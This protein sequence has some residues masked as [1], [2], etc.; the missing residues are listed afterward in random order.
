[1]LKPNIYFYGSSYETTDVIRLDFLGKHP[2]TICIST[3][4][5]I[6]DS[7]YEMVLKTKK[8]LEDM[9]I[10]DLSFDGFDAETIILQG[11]G[12]QVSFTMSGGRMNTARRGIADLLLTGYPEIVEK[13][14]YVLDNE[15]KLH[16]QGQLE[17]W[18]TGKNGPTYM[19]VLLSPYG[20]YY[21][22]FYPWLPENFM[23]EYMASTASILFLTGEPG[24]GKTSILR[25]LICSRGLNAAA[26][27][28]ENILSHDEMFLNF[29]TSE[30]MNLIIIEDADNILTPR[31]SNK[32]NLIS[33]F[34]NFS[35]GL[36]KFPN[37]KIIFTTNLH[38]FN[39]VDDA[40]TR[41]GRCF[42]VKEA[43]KLTYEEAVRAAE[44]ASLPIPA[45]EKK[46]TLADLLHQDQRYK[47]KHKGTGF[48]I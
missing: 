16:Q 34:L 44:V 3:K 39:N 1:M 9:R 23:D 19:N 45:T 28:D 43:R 21:P 26:T 2:N 27:Y 36:A 42:G 22:E 38:N 46:Y 7:L 5:V 37:K 15:Y 30:K 24:T 13:L 18:Y 31:A 40:L 14:L 17:L 11:N 10:E 20:T 6:D 33:R 32:N 35:E 4:Y 29:L 8:Q 25:D 48:G 47:V 41:S 12:V